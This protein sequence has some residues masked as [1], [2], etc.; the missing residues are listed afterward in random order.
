MRESF[1]EYV[2]A[3]SGRLLRFAYVLCGDRFLAEDLVQDVLSRTHRHW[4]RIESENPNAYLRT[5]LV[6]AHLSWRRRRVSTEKVLADPP[7]PGAASGD[8]TQ[9]L[10]TRDEMWSLLATLP[11]AQRAV[12]VLRFYEDLD[13]RRIADVLGCA[14]VT[15]RVHASRALGTLRAGLSRPIT[16]PQGDR[17]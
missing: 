15:V 2:A 3:S 1:E 8:F 17:R 14:P 9:Q 6:R 5:A 12:M 11:R 13:D 7:E 10:A 16:Q 4:G